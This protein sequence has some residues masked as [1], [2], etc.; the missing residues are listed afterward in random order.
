MPCG[1]KIGEEQD[2]QFLAC[3][4]QA[5]VRGSLGLARV[6]VTSVGPRGQLELWSEQGVCESSCVRRLAW[7]VTPRDPV[8]PGTGGRVAGILKDQLR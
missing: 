4:A 2:A 5:S 6:A 8:L 1:V 3:G 7:A